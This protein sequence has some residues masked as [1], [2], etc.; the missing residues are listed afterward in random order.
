MTYEMSFI[1]NR[2]VRWIPRGWQHPKDGRGKY[3]PLLPNGYCAANGLTEAD[4]NGVGEMPS[5]TG[6]VS[7]QGLEIMAYETTTEG[8]PISPAFPDTPEGRLELIRWCAEHETTFG[9]FKAGA[10]A[11]AG[12]LFTDRVVTV[13]ARDGSI[14]IP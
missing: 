6:P 14:R 7:L 4:R 5:V 8:T 13:D 10:E 3:V 11:W 2:E 1:P 9:D 12:L